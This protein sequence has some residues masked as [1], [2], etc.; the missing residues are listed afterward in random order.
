MSVSVSFC[1]F[2]SSFSEMAPFYGAE[3]L[4]DDSLWSADGSCQNLFDSSNKISYLY[5]KKIATNFSQ[6]LYIY[7]LYADVILC[8]NLVTDFVIEYLRVV[9]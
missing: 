5:K 3:D 7:L 4:R 1:L 6:H 2:L 8:L 9:S